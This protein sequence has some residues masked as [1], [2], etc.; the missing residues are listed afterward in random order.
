MDKPTSALFDVFL[1]LRPATHPAERFLNVEPVNEH[2]IPTHVT[3]HPPVGDNRKRAV[4]RF[5][6]TQVFEEETEQ[7]ELFTNTG[8]VEMIQ[9]VFGEP[10]HQGRDGTIATLGVT[11][12]GKSHTI[13]GSRAQRGIVQMTLDT[14]FSNAASHL[15]PVKTSNTA[16]SSLCAADVTEAQLT[17][18]DDFLESLIYDP[19]RAS[20]AATPAL[21]TSFIS[22]MVSRRYLPDYGTLPTEPSVEGIDMT[23]DDSAEFAF[24]VS[25]YE[26]YNDKI[27]DLL[28]PSTSGKAVAKRRAL[29]FKITEL[30][31]DRKVV[32]GLRK[33]VCTS[34]EEAILVLEAG[35]HERK[36]AGTGS[37]ATSS[38]SHGFFCVEV[39]KRRRSQV[40]GPWTSSALTIVD[41]AGSE[42]A[43]LAGTAGQTLAEAG[44]INSSLM[45]LGQCMQT[46]AENLSSTNPSRMPYRQCKLTE[47]LFSNTFAQQPQKYQPQKAIMI[48]TAD[49]LGDFNG[50]SQILRYSALAKEITVPRIP[51]TT[52]TLHTGLEHR[53]NADGRDS[54]STLQGDFDAAIETIAALRAE[55]EIAQLQ[56]IEEQERR[57]DAEDAWRASEA[58]MDEIEAETRDECWREFETQMRLEQRRWRAARDAEMELQDAHVDAKLEILTRG[59]TCVDVY[60]DKENEGPQDDEYTQSPTKTTKG[61]RS[62]ASGGTPSAKIRQSKSKRWDGSSLGV[63]ES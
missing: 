50:T 6:F 1:R 8:I 43:R 58:R 29:L 11:G 18:A 61:L 9:G 42:R 21:E 27:H 32:A 52:S 38:R 17:L 44:K 15:A 16:F 20:R 41:M 49:P 39:K 56:L 37:N 35:I 51:S 47:L 53:L 48:V 2:G 14:I 3:V 62:K 40:P 19:S 45:Y 33:V 12:S 57:L 22:T 60:E 24:V 34:L 10:A 30:S 28:I 55:L 63:D 59:L 4:E 7:D 26:V 25:M 23:I 31:Q 54:P 36:V 5:A 46:Q 13:L